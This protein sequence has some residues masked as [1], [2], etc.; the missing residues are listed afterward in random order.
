MI[1]L[2]VDVVTTRP[3]VFRWKQVVP[4]PIGSRVVDYEAAL[5]AN[6]EEAVAALVNVAKGL[7]AENNKLLA[8]VELMS[9]QLEAP[10]HVAVQATPPSTKGGRK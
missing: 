9:K 5:P 2:P 1:Q 10:P 6:V 7:V 3:L 4:S 8:Q